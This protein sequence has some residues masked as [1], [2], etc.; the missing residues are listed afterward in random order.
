[1]MMMMMMMVI[2]VMMMMM[3]MIV[4]RLYADDGNFSVD[5]STGFIML[6]YTIITL[7]YHVNSPLAL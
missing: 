7:C 2:M 5:V 4:T 3:M 1:M 6:F